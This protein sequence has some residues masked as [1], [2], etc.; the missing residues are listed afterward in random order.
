MQL[1]ESAADPVDVVGGHDEAGA[2][3]ANE[4]GRG[5]VRRDDSEDRPSR[6]EVLEHLPGQHSAPAAVRVRHE[7]E[8]CLGVA[9]EPKRLGPRR[10]RHELEA[11][12]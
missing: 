4:I 8:Q 6:G 5:A 10:I 3:R 9:L 2:G 11:V 12:S 1:L 7:Q